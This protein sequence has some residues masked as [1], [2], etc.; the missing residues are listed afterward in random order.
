MH[1]LAGSRRPGR[2]EIREIYSV[3]VNTL[4]FLRHFHSITH[5]FW[6][7]HDVTLAWKFQPVLY[8]SIGGAIM[9]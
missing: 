8:V 5:L 6:T 9:R 2:C 3:K 1:V 4:H 7:I